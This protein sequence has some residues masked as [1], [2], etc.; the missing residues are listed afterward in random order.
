M[1][2]LRLSTEK[3]DTLSEIEGSGVTKATYE[4]TSH[5][6][7]FK[8]TAQVSGR[9]LLLLRALESERR[10]EAHG[11]GGSSVLFR[12]NKFSHN[13]A[14]PIEGPK[15][16][17]WDALS[18]REEEGEEFQNF[19]NMKFTAQDKFT[20]DKEVMRFFKFAEVLGVR[21]KDETINTLPE[22]GIMERIFSD[23]DSRNLGRVI[24]FIGARGGVGSSTLAANTAHLLGQQFQDSVILV[25]LD[26][27][28]GTAALSLNL[29]PRQNVAEALADPNRLD[30]VLMERF[31]LKYD[32]HLSVV[33]AP[34]VLEGNNNIDLD[35]FEILVK[36]LQQ[37]ASFVVLDLPH[38]WPSWMPEVLFDAN[39]V[40]ATAGLDLACLRDVKNMFDNLA[41]KRGVDAPT[42]LVF[43]RV[44]AAA[45]TELSP[46]DFEEPA[47][48]SPAAQIAFDPVLFGTALNNGE[49]LAEVNNSS[50]VVKE[51]TNLANIVSAR[52]SVGKLSKKGGALASL[53]RRNK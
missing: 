49:M 39:E 8:A 9:R 41:P 16:A 20:T 36:I 32:D 28:F 18:V 24:A 10:G 25:D 37:M 11:S 4:E 47:K 15:A 27:P 48:V 31:M 52:T 1:A 53:L 42:R 13:Q 34:A 12:Q 21:P 30:D 3:A 22:M 17:V 2:L 29:Q 23:A 44:G 40:V 26:L 33:A 38:Q 7:D 14:D 46:S 5:A 19:Y 45:K 43:N 6:S 51:L 35:S 50:R